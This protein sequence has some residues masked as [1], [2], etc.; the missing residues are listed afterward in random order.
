MPPRKQQ[1]PGTSF[2]N[3]WP[4]LEQEVAPPPQRH[5]HDNDSSPYYLH[6]SETPGAVLVT[7]ILLGSSNYHS[8]S[9]GILL[10]LDAKNKTAFIDGTISQPNPDDLLFPAW[11][12]VNSM[13]KSWIL[14]SVSKEFSASLLGFHT[15]ADLWSD[16]R[17]RF[18]ESDGPRIFAIKKS[19]ATLVQ[20]AMDINTYY[21]RMK[22]LWDELADYEEDLPC[23]CSALTNWNIRQ[24]REAVYQ[25]LMGLNDTY[26]QVRGHVLL[27][28]PMPSLCKV[29]A[30]VLQEERQRKI[31]NHY[32]SVDSSF[33]E[34]HS[35]TGSIYDNQPGSTPATSISATPVA[36]AVSKPRGSRPYCTHCSCSGHTID[37]CYKLHGYPTGSKPRPA[38]SSRDSFGSGVAIADRLTNDQWK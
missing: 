30:L 3:P 21:T 26:S 9:R 32:S 29:F 19:L 37:K 7:T 4:G 13:V 34:I 14:N 11:K 10:A 28:D 35:T 17:S 20:G 25:F 6:N 5:V 16:L 22:I 33:G 2:Q 24:Q 15:A 1:F 18:Q 36:M 38:P 8:W 23:S 27:Q 31:S 12:R